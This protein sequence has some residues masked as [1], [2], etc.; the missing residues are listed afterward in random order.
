MY[1]Q[2]HSYFALKLAKVTS[3]VQQCRG[4]RSRDFA[5]F[6]RSSLGELLLALEALCTT[7]LATTAKASYKLFEFFCEVQNSRYTGLS[8]MVVE[9]LL[10]QL[11]T[12]LMNIENSL[13]SHTSHYM[14]T[15]VLGSIFAKYISLLYIVYILGECTALWG[16]HEQVLTSCNCNDR[17]D[18]IVE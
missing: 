17:C 1:I 15:S 2:Q 5:V 16:K 12:I 14:V 8:Q 9:P 10:Q 13:T 7:L 11:A 4:T 18:N 6:F 3:Y